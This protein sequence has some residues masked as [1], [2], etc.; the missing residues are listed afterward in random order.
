MTIDWSETERKV[1]KAIRKKN[2]NK[3]LAI[4]QEADLPDCAAA[5][6]TKPLVQH[7]FVCPA[8]HTRVELPCGLKSCRFHVDNE[9]ANNCVLAYCHQQNVEK[10]SPDEISYLYAVPAEKVVSQLDTAMNV[11]RLGAIQAQAQEDPDVR[12]SF[13]F[14]ET[15][16][17]CCVCGSFVDEPLECRDTP[18][19][20]CSDQCAKRMPPEAVWL[21]WKFG[22][23]VDVLLLWAFRRFRHLPILEK[24]FNLNRA[25][26]H[27]LSLRFL[28]RPLREFYPKSKIVPE[29][30]SLVDKLRISSIKQRVR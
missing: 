8:H 22:R 15:K 3:A 26:L 5:L 25:T 17:V 30:T 13:W 2:T 9:L 29:T 4:L 23:Q 19:A 24:T 6:N 7:D 14:V 12:R 18:F 1:L 10:L 21:E 16:A 28:K 20:Y 11:M 27:S